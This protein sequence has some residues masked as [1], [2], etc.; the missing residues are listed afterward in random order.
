MH[1][2]Q[3]QGTQQHPHTTNIAVNT[4]TVIINDRIIARYLPIILIMLDHIEVSTPECSFNSSD[5]VLNLDNAFVKE[6]SGAVLLGIK[7]VRTL[8][9]FQPGKKDT[10]S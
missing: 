9:L 1:R 3:R 8:L 5:M 10:D 6:P 4:A 7:D 2:E